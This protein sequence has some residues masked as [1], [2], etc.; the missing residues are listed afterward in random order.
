MY[1]LI[2]KISCVPGKRDELIHIL[3]GGVSSLPGNL[4][5]TVAAD[6]VEPDGIWITEVWESREAHRESL[7]L[8]EVQAVIEKGR[9]LIVEFKERYETVP[10]GGPGLL[11]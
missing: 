10:V 6:E 7:Q 11:V 8:P 9:P 4:Q 3:I 1:G 2:G 5:Y